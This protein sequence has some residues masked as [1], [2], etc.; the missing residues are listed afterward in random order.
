MNV[1]ACVFEL[2][3]LPIS[4]V[5]QSADDVPRDR[6]LSE[7]AGFLHARISRQKPYSPISGSRK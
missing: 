6:H 4:L 7:I 5:Y 2:A 1:A 3:G